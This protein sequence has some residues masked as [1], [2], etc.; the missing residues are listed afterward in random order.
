[1]LDH[2]AKPATGLFLAGVATVL[3]KRPALA[4]NLPDGLSGH[5]EDD[6]RQGITLAQQGRMVEID[7]HQVS[8]AAHLQSA[9]RLVQGG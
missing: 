8:S 5:G 3:Q 6:S 2:L 1:L 9:G 7:G 4:K